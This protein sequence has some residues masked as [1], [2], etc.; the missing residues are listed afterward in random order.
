MAKTNLSTAAVYVKETAGYP[1]GENAKELQEGRCETFCEEHGLEIL[2]RY[3][4]APGLRHGFQRMMD[5]ATGE[6]P[7]FEFIV[8][9]KLRN[10]SWSLEETVLCR[11][12]LTANG[13]TLV[14]TS[15]SS[16]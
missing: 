7:P 8:V 10:F 14:S 15:E 3:H 16:P 12:R 2:R 1:N 13:V 5:D 9:Y 4:D 6:D 11:D